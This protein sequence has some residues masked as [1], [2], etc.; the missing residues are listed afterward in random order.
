MSFT[1]EFIN[2]L[3]SSIDMV[4]LAKEEVHDLRK[5]GKYVWT[6][7]CPHPDHEDSSPSFTVWE[8]TNKWTCFG[9]N[10]GKADDCIGY[11][12]WLHGFTFKEAIMY[13]AAKAGINIEDDALTNEYNSLE[14]E[15]KKYQASI[16]NYAMSYYTNRNIDQCDIEKYRL[17]YD[18]KNKRIVFPLIDKT[19]R[20]VGFIKRRTFD[21][22]TGPKYINSK[23]SDVFNKSKFLYNMNNLDKNFKYIRIVE[24]TMDAIM[25]SKYGAKNV[26]ATLGTALTQEHVNII[27]KLGMTP[28]LIFDSDNAGLKATSSSLDLFYK[29]G[30]YCN[31]CP[32]KDSKDLCDKSIELETEI[33]DF[34]SNNSITYGYAMAQDIINSYTKD[35]YEIRLKYSKKINTIVDKIPEEEK[36]AIDSF[37]SDEIRMRL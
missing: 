18:K 13:L 22:K 25:A 12:M 33:E 29:N 32:L 10:N 24:G 20:V 3:K 23:T 27:K 17:G 26:V 11:V 16:D 5:T 4:S 15:C 9:C 35:I 19:N 36:K 7:T 2:E 28:V 6:G 34:I 8:N 31:I 1:N 21:D 30:I 14:N 37:L